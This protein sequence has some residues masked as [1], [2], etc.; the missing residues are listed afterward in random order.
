MLLN[1]PQPA[2]TCSKLTIKALNKVRNMFKVNNK[3]T[4]TTPGV[5]LVSLL[6]TLNIFH[7]L[8]TAFIVNFG[9]VIAGWVR[10]CFVTQ[11]L[12]FAIWESIIFAEIY[13]IYRGISSRPVDFLGSNSLRVAL[14]GRIEPSQTKFNLILT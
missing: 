6:L 12:M 8:F 1:L 13:S 11:L 7:T 4:R 3:D 10:E 14:D 5:V 2:I 9:Q